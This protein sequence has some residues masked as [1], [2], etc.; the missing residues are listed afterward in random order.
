MMKYEP[1]FLTE[2]WEAQD[3]IYEETKHLTTKQL[4]KQI[5]KD[6]DEFLKE[7]GYELVPVGG[8]MYKMKKVSEITAHEPEAELLSAEDV[9]K[10]VA[11]FTKALAQKKAER[12]TQTVLMREDI[13]QIFDNLLSVGVFR[14]EEEIITRALQALFV[15]VSPHAEVAMQKGER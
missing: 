11:S 2:L 8:G 5:R 3:E 4:G 1:E 15:A 7:Q 9:D 10:D 6:A 14:D 12:L 13:R